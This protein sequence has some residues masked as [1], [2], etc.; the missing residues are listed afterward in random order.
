VGESSVQGLHVVGSWHE[1]ECG[2]R[3]CWVIK[4]T[5]GSVEVGWLPLAELQ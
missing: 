3:H 5:G 1:D 4:K 2:P